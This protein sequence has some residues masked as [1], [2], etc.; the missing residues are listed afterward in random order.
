VKARIICILFILGIVV[1]SI[2]GCMEV[3]FPS[4][5]LHETASGVV[6]PS[7]STTEIPHTTISPGISHPKVMNTV[8]SATAD[9]QGKR[10]LAVFLQPLDGHRVNQ[11][12][13]DR[14]GVD[15][16]P[17]MDASLYE[18]KVLMRLEKELLRI[19]QELAHTIVSREE[20]LADIQATT[21][22]EA[23][24][25]DRANYQMM[26]ERLKNR[27]GYEW[28]P[29]ILLL[30][31]GFDLDEPVW[32]DRVN[33]FTIKLSLEEKKLL[34]EQN[35][36]DHISPIS[37]EGWG[38]APDGDPSHSN[39]SEDTAPS[40][41][42]DDGQT[43]EKNSYWVFCTGFKV[44]GMTTEEAAVQFLRELYGYDADVY[45][46]ESRYESEYLP[47]L[48]PIV[49][50]NV[51]NPADES[52]RAEIPYELLGITPWQEDEEVYHISQVQRRDKDMIT[53]LRLLVVS[54]LCAE[55]ADR[56]LTEMEVDPANVYEIDTYTSTVFLWATEEDILR[57][58]EC[59]SVLTIGLWEPD[60]GMAVESVSHTDASEDSLTLA[61][62]TVASTD[63]VFPGSIYTGVAV[64]VGVIEAPIKLGNIWYGRRFDPTAPQITSSRFTYVPNMKDGSLL[65]DAVID[66]HATAVVSVLAGKSKTVNQN[67]Y[68]GI[69]PNAEV[70]QTSFYTE[71]QFKN[72]LILLAD[73]G[74]SVI[75]ASIGMTLNNGDYD[76]SMAQY[77]DS[78]IRNTWIPIVISAGN[79]TENVMSPGYSY[80]AITV[81]NAETV[82]AD[83][84][85]LEAPY[86]IS[87]SSNYA[88]FPLYVYKPDIV[89][90]GTHIGVVLEAGE[91]TRVSGTSFSAPMV[92]GV[93]AQMIQAQSAWIFHVPETLKAT[94][95]A[96]ANP[97][98]LAD[99][100][101]E[102]CDG[103]S[104]VRDKS[105]AGM[106][107]AVAATNF[108]TM[109]SGQAFYTMLD[110]LPRPVTLHYTVE[111]QA[112]DHIRCAMTFENLYTSP[113]IPTNTVN[114][115]L[116]LISP[117]QAEI[118]SSR[119][120]YNNVEILEFTA[121]QAGVY[122]IEVTF[123]SGTFYSNR[124]LYVGT[125]Y[126]IK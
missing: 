94:L 61:T 37:T 67:N 110:D 21:I 23:V 65:I 98:L 32:G 49:E 82:S 2:A 16:A 119:S 109:S 29:N 83:G 13:L 45:A 74:V 66:E 99:P 70:Y 64:K 84:Y 11:A 122:T 4:T 125:A 43:N 54:E 20:M 78:F 89:A 120:P 62:N 22:E 7:E 6:A 34:E 105:G 88:D 55:Q 15:L 76:S 116:A 24:A 19:Q 115:D 40:S 30:E 47:A 93:L 87:G 9:E 118:A 25:Q 18:S 58:A 113:N 117:T 17:Y 36:V 52:L 39:P 57:Y 42:K 33:C 90:P 92:T 51:M 123:E 50:R 126:I 91:V 59:E 107:D 80:N 56:F 124:L 72:A 96:T 103:T 101:D 79:A 68:H 104:Y 97:A 108:V 81:G 44:T 48:I 3:P 71:E 106:A 31:L 60:K 41:E 102:C 111:L 28:L 1:T 10:L 75:N 69:A 114:L 63:A 73:Q 46:S 121:V 77:V 35:W 12:V 112:G 14:Y 8:W 5:G 27:K 38:S 100:S 85:M 26:R 86:G 53:A 95:L